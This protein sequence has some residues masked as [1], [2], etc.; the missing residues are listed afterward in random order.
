MKQVACGTYPDSEQYGNA[1]RGYVGSDTSMRKWLL[2]YIDAAFDRVA[3]GDGMTLYDAAYQADYGF[4]PR[5][6]ELAATAERRDWRHVP[7]EHLFE[8]HDAIFFMD[9]AAKKFYTPA[10]LR[11]VLTEGT[12]NRTLYDA[13]LFDLSGFVRAKPINDIPFSQLYDAKQRAAF[14]RF[15]KFAAFNAP[16]TFGREAPLR[17]LDRIRRLE[18]AAPRIKRSPR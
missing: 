10:I 15:C 17:I 7:I 13:F 1:I 11:A 6:L 8:R 5:E 14:V 16:R 2:Q 18:P 4:C 3:L 12:R 9:S